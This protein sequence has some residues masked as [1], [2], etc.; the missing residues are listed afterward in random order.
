MSISMG[1]LAKPCPAYKKRTAAAAKVIHR[2][3][4]NLSIIVIDS[5]IRNL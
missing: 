5:W 1:V 4:K 2:F 3:A